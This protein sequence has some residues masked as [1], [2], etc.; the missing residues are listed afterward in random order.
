[1]S[2]DVEFALN[3]VLPDDLGRELQRLPSDG[4]RVEAV[5]APDEDVT[6]RFGLAEAVTLIGVVKGV[7]DAVKVGLELLRLLKERAEK[8]RDPGASASLSVPDGRWVVVITSD[9]QSAE[10]ES[11]IR[12]ALT[13]D[14]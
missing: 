7:F 9:M 14:K 13:R 6:A 4:F 5:S 12:Q 8:K 1:M 10:V 2:D 3:V 11:A